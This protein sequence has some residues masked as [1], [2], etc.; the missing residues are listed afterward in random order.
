MDTNKDIIRSFPGLEDTPEK[1]VG[2]IMS[3]R[4]VNGA[5]LYQPK[6]R[7]I[8]LCVADLYVF[9]ANANDFTE[10]KLSV[11]FSRANFMQTA[12]QLYRDNG[13]PERADKLIASKRKITIK[14]RTSKRW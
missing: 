12:I 8:N 7:L 1:F 10:N 11:T 14:G 6:D 9:M 4:S 3:D 5:A 13:E 2:K